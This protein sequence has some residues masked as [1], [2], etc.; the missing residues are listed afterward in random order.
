MF[1]KK[2]NPPGA[3]PAPTLLAPRPVTKP[4]DPPTVIGRECVVIGNITHRVA[5][6]RAV[7]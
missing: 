1:T 4:A 6:P 3:I 2:P 5:G 7:K